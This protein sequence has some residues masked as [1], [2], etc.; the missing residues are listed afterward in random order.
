M[1]YTFANPETG[2]ES[3]SNFRTF[4]F[5]PKADYIFPPESERPSVESLLHPFET[6]DI[7][8]VPPPA[9]QGRLNHPPK[10]PADLEQYC[11]EVQASRPR[12]Y[13]NAKNRPELAGDSRPENGESL[14]FGDNPI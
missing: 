6:S 2:E 12:Y 7:Q 11:G 13:A 10:D 9:E 4:P 5:D 14:P 1:S 8:S 3:P